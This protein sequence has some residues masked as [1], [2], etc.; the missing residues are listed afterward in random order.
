M[1]GIGDIDVEGK[2]IL[3]VEDI[4]DTGR[5]MSRLLEELKVNLYV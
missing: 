1:T 5:S 3:I 2:E 4:V